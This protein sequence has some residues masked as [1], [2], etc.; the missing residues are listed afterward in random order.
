MMK[1]PS[2]ARH[3]YDI[4]AESNAELQ[5]RV[6]DLVDDLREPTWHYEYRIKEV[7]SFALK[8]ESGRV[9]DPYSLEDF[10]GC[11]LVV[12]NALE[13]PGQSMQFASVSGL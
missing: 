12:R 11:T 9:P 13:V 10:F 5:Q 3:A 1:I 6:R 2:A 8:L 4:Q 7:E